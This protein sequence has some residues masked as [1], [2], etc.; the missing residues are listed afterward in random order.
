MIVPFERTFYS[1][2]LVTLDVKKYY[3]S[4]KDLKKI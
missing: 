1:F 3:L 4:F 2:N